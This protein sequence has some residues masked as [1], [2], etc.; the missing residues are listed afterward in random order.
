MGEYSYIFSSL[1]EV[2]LHYQVK[3]SIDM[4][5]DASLPNGKIYHY[6]LLENEEIKRHI[7]ELFHKGHIHP[8]SSPC[9]S[10]IMLVQKKDGTWRLCFDY[11]ALNKIK[12]RNRYPIPRIDNLL[13][14]LMGAK[15]FSNIDLKSSYH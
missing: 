5:L 7:Q 13:D 3:H 1:T 12:V 11:R 14:Q 4:T 6:S 9:G 8:S 2:P 15:Y 10:P